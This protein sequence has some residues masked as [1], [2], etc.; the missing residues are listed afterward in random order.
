MEYAP[1]HGN[2]IRQDLQT[3]LH[4]VPAWMQQW[5][6]ELLNMAS[7]PANEAPGAWY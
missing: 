4:T 1:D 5:L 6:R 2:A 7:L 3:G